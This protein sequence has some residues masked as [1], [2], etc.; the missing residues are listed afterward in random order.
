M[1]LIVKE[2]FNRRF[3]VNLINDVHLNIVQQFMLSIECFNIHDLI[4]IS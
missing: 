1:Q 2:G 4:N 3:Q